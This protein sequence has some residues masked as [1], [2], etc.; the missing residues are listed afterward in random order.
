MFQDKIRTTSVYQNYVSR[1]ISSG[2]SSDSSFLRF[3]KSVN[4]DLFYA[5]HNVRVNTTGY[6]VG[7]IFVSYVVNIT[8]VFDFSYDNDYD[9]LFTALVNNWA[10]LC[11]QTHV[12]HPIPVAIMIVH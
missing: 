1:V 8:D 9:D 12:L 6:N 2:I 5:L 7:S 3:T 4:A 10:W 11:Q